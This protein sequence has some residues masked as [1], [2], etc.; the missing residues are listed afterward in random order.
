MKRDN[1]LIAM[2]LTIIL[3]MSG[4]TVYQIYSTQDS[5]GFLLV[6]DDVVLSNYINDSN[7]YTTISLNNTTNFGE[8]GSPSL[9]VYQF[10]LILRKN[11]MVKNVETEVREQKDIFLDFIPVPEQ[12]QYPLCFG[13]NVSGDL[14]INESCYNSS[15]LTIGKTHLSGVVSYKKGT[16]ILSVTVFPIDYEGKNNK[17][18]FSKEIFLRVNYE[19]EESPLDDTLDYPGGICS[20]TESFKWV[21]VV[22]ETM[23]SAWQPLVQHRQSHNGFTARTV[24]MA[25]ILAEPAY[26][27]SDPLFND[28][29]ARLREFCKDAYTD[30]GTEYLLLGGDGMIYNY[31]TQTWNDIVPYREFDT[32]VSYTWHTMPCDLYFSNLDDD[33]YHNGVWGGGYN[34]PKDLYSELKVGRICVSTPEHVSNAIQKIIWYDN[35]NSDEDWLRTCCFIGDNLGWSVTAK[36]YMEELRLGTG[37]FSQYEG[38]EEFKADHPEYPLNT[39]WNRYYYSDTNQWSTLTHNA[40]EN[41]NFS[42]IN[43]LG[44]SSP[45]SPFSMINWAWRFNTQPFFGW[46]QGCLAG[47]FSGYTAGSEQLQCSKDESHAYG[48]VLNTG[49][50]WGSTGSTCGKSQQQQKIFW[51]Y[52]FEEKDDN[53]EEWFLGD[54]HTYQKDTYGPVSQYSSIGCYAWYS[55]HY[56]GD[57][58]S[59]LRFDVDGGIQL[60]IGHNY[61]SYTGQNTTLKDIANNIPLDPSE[62]IAKQVNGSWPSDYVWIQGFTPDILNKP[63]YTGDFIDI[64]VKSNKTWVI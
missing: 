48:L 52:F 59:L 42:I 32:L 15:E 50:G 3:V 17:L 30:W 55:S 64:V 60:N 25:E 63:V 51:N 8:P 45:N 49:Y 61:M 21:A 4:L 10:N 58:A 39:T 56:F 6:F 44:H 37:C 23:E 33:W 2:A 9:P 57:P 36:Q 22:N 13:Q 31:T 19:E 11:R 28:S 26:Y 46:S 62:Y 7:F 12:P 20:D 16:P 43:H 34:A 5:E 53:P 29:A 47:R 27:N 40:I 35:F 41:N 18:I 1:K 14:F 38:F 24:T 54:A